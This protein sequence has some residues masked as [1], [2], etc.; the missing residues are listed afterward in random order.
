M[1][2]RSDRTFTFGAPR[3]AVWQALGA[4]DAYTTWWPWLRRLDAAALAAGETWHCTIRPPVPYTVRCTI[5]L[6]ELETRRMVAA[7][8]AGDISGHARV[9]LA[10]DAAGTSVRLVSHLAPSG[11]WT[12]LVT[13][14][15]P[16]VARWGHDRVI[17]TAA[18]QFAAALGRPAVDTSRQD[19][20][21]SP[22]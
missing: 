8:V 13:P 21:R 19:V 22:G 12:G 3:P 18:A 17:R 1:Q 9:E 2:I 7:T 6:D 5:R 14:I 16:R 11:R 10:D 15:A 4:V 20:D